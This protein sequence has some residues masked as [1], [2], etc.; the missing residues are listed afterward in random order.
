[1]YAALSSAIHSGVVALW[2]ASLLLGLFRRPVFL[3]VALFAAYGVANTS[4]GRELFL[5]PFLEDPGAFTR[6]TGFD[7]QVTKWKVV[8]WSL[9][10]ILPL[11]VLATFSRSAYA[12]PLG[13][14]GLYGV[15]GFFTVFV[16]G[17]L[18]WGADEGEFSN[19]LR[20]AN[21]LIA[22]LAIQLGLTRPGWALSW[23]IWLFAL[24]DVIR[25]LMVN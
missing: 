20:T 6:D 13:M 11:L 15:L 7:V 10:A 16:A 8:Y 2:A 3:I 1:M 12:S 4:V 22:L 17:V 25:I 19:A 5:S 23:A 18:I 9:F 24:S 21:T 14:I